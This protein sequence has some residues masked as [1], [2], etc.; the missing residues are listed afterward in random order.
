MGGSPDMRSED[1]EARLLQLENDLAKERDDLA[2]AESREREDERQAQERAKKMLDKQEEEQ[3]L[4][5]IEKQE[6]VAADVAS[7]LVDESDFDSAATD[8]FSSLLFGAGGAGEGA[9]EGEDTEEA[10]NSEERPE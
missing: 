1:A 3:R 5:E 8:M 6:Q 9:G 10:S 2:R 4:A 7:S